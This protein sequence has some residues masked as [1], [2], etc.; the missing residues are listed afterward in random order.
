MEYMKCNAGLV[1]CRIGRAFIYN[2]VMR[3]I[4]HL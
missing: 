3:E 2:L 1:K 4:R